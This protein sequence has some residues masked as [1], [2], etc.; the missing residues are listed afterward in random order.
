MSRPFFAVYSLHYFFMKNGWARPQHFLPA[1]VR[2]TEARRR[3]ARGHKSLWRP[4]AVVHFRIGSFRPKLGENLNLL[5]PSLLLHRLT[6]NSG[7][8]HGHGPLVRQ[9]F[10]MKKNI[11]KERPCFAR[12]MVI[13]A[14]STCY[15]FTWCEFTAFVCVRDSRRLIQV[16]G[17]AVSSERSLPG[18]ARNFQTY[19]CRWTIP[20][21]QINTAQQRYVAYVRNTRHKSLAKILLAD[22][23]R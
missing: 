8:A 4:I 3:T 21:A 18:L 9:F 17:S 22:P 12:R 6:D 11:T 1:C 7:I 23:F 14:I 2:E 20:T 10:T 15:F 5:L 19:A 16:T 13:I